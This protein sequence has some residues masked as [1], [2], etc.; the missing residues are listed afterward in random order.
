M[1]ELAASVTSGRV[2]GEAIV[3]L[4]C[5]SSDPLTRVTVRANTTAC[6]EGSRDTNVASI[7]IP[8][9][10]FD[11]LRDNAA[12]V[13]YA[14]LTVDDNDSTKVTDFDFSLRY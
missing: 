5:P 7:K 6:C 9:C 8:E 13:C 12:S 3:I 2:F 10:D 1:T 14:V 4:N 11:A